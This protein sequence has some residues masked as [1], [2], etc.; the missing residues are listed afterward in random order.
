MIEGTCIYS[1][2]S[3]SLFAFQDGSPSS[4]ISFFHMGTVAF[5]VSIANCTASRDSRL[6]S[7]E[8]AMITLA[9][10][11]G[12]TPSL[13]RIQ[14]FVTLHFSRMLL[15]IFFISFSAMGTYP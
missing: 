1:C 2:H 10:S 6:C 4:Y 3:H 13:C 9:C 15:Q 7:E 11:T 14:M 8:I 5:S 12:T